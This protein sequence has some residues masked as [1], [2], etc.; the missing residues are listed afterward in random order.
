MRIKRNRLNFIAG[1][2]LS[3]LVIIAISG[4]GSKPSYWKLYSS[5]EEEVIPSRGVLQGRSIVIDPGHG[6]EFRGVVGTGK[7][8]EAD[9][10]LGVALYLWGMLKNAGAEVS[11]TRTIDRDFLPPDSDELSVDL[12]N[13]MI[14]ANSFEADVFIS[15][16]HNSSLP[17]KRERNRIEVYY[18]NNDHGGS[19]E[20][21]RMTRLHLDRNLGIDM[22][23]VKPGNY[24]VLRNSN[25][26]AA[27]LGEASYLS[28]PVV[29]DSLKLASKQKL[30]AQAYF[31]ALQNYFSR[32][33][34]SF[35]LVSPQA[36]TLRH[37]PQIVYHVD[38]IRGLDPSSARIY[39]NGREF[40]PSMEKG[41]GTIYFGPEP[42]APNGEYFIR[43]SIRSVGG[44][45]GSSRPFRFVIN[46][47]PGY[48]LPLPPEAEPDNSVTIS[49]RILDS[50]GMPVIDRSPVTITSIGS[51]EKICCETCD[52]ICSFRVGEEGLP[53][54]FIISAWGV[55]DTLSF[56]KPAET[57]SRIIQ[58]TDSRTGEPVQFP[59]VAFPGDEILLE[60]SSRGKVSLP[61]PLPGREMIVFSGGYKPE[62][63]D[64]SILQGEELRHTIAL[65][66]L[67]RGNLAGKR[68]VLDP[69]HGGDHHGTTGR[70][71][72]RESTINAAI[73]GSV[74]D[75]LKACGADVIMTRNGEETVSAEERLAIANRFRPD[76][77]ISINHDMGTE[78]TGGKYLINHYPGSLQG[79]RIANIIGEL[80]ATLFPE[81]KIET[82][83]SAAI[84]L[85]HTVCPAVEI[86]L[87][88]LSEEGAEEIIYSPGYNYYISERIFSAVSEY[89]ET[90]QSI[91]LNPLTVKVLSGGM[92]LEGCY[93]TLDN[94]LTL[95]GGK[96][97][98]ARFSNVY[99]GDHLIVV[100]K[101]GETIYRGIHRRPDDQYAGAIEIETAE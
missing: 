70:K 79:E 99:S 90:G 78:E 82:G 57:G 7:V 11:L 37:S 77:A 3:G 20:L 25:A 6:G 9:V 30:E 16:H 81:G 68:I 71:K 49:A 52:G 95:P 59:L 89:F 53:G 75:L 14:R 18:R 38:N 26:G 35:R 10:N 58:L 42:D 34:P 31:I 88:S 40:I 17:L 66:P 91:S 60:G 27:I 2:I 101:D 41:S 47:P 28:H 23:V 73:A 69:A 85:T 29:E 67:S 51:K 15:I 48:F 4:C 98:S 36:D 84:F 61:S 96:S 45:T 44:I 13:R 62:R 24:F 76:L 94:L 80:M 97:G 93:V 64:S 19:A 72:I 1:M 8:S 33:V 54:T 46:R 12:E 21:A 63:V 39:I 65:E 55:T 86:H 74:R 87:G 22:S 100:Q 5:M 43:S 83:E 56:G 32:G 92:P 50:N